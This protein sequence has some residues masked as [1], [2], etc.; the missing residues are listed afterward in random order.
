MTM[1]ILKSILREFLTL[2]VLVNRVIIIII[3]LLLFDFMDHK[4]L[5]TD[6]S[7]QSEHY[8]W[9]GRYIKY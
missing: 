4:H 5:F 3:S 7:L 2:N 6:D 1:P 9:S 8:K